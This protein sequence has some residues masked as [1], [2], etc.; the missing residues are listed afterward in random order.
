MRGW[1]SG[2]SIECVLLIVALVSAGDEH[3]N[4]NGDGHY[5][6]AVPPFEGPHDEK[7]NAH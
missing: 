4:Q 1:C 6:E 7:T 3:F 5:E 2:R